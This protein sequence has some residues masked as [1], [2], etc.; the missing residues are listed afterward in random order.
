MSDENPFSPPKTDLSGESAKH[1]SPNPSDGLGAGQ[2]GPNNDEPELAEI[3]IRF[4]GFVIDNILLLI[5]V[6][7]AMW[8]GGYFK[9]AM[10]G[11]VGI[12]EVLLW[13][14]ISFGL[15]VLL[16]GY[17]LYARGQTWAKWLL[18]IRIVDLQGKQPEFWRLLV[19]RYLAP[20]VLQAIPL[21]GPAFSL[22]DALYIFGAQR[23]CL[24]DYF[25]GTR[26]INVQ[27][28]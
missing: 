6:I 14:A 12:G 3:I 15:M 1:A 27:R 20:G 28:R 5:F 25:A 7:P 8:F 17:P 24:H 22:A 10:T 2:T 16:Q 18:D 9:A 13:T 26:V 23:R 4:L 19:M 21:L 11:N